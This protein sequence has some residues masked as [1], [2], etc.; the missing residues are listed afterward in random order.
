MK[1]K[2]YAYKSVEKGCYSQPKFFP[3]SK[4]DMITEVKRSLIGLDKKTADEVK[5]L[6]LVYLGIFDD[7][8]GKIDYQKEELIALGPYIRIKEL[9]DET[10]K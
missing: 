7:N 1:L 10:S 2:I 8:E 4:E 6:T 5:D 9:S 3:Y